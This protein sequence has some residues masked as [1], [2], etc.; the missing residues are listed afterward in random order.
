V[1]P[2]VHAV[3]GGA[4]GY[5]QCSGEF[6]ANPSDCAILGVLLGGAGGAGIGALIGASSKTDRW[7]EIPLDRWRV[8][9]VATRDGRFGLAASLRF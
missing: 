2:T 3:V 1:D 7:E 6:I 8:T 4:G 5:A 9:P